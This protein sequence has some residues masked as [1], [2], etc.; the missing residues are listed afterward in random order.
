MF[1][2]PKL[3]LEHYGTKPLRKED[4]VS[5]G[6]KFEPTGEEYDLAVSLVT[7]NTANSLKDVAEYLE[8]TAPDIKK[9]YIFVNSGSI[10][11]SAEL[12]PLLPFD[13]VVVSH[14]YDEAIE[15]RYS[16]A[17]ALNDAFAIAHKLGIKYLLV[18]DIDAYVEEEGL[19]Q[20]FNVLKKAPKDVIAV[21]CPPTGGYEHRVEGRKDEATVLSW[22]SGWT[23]AITKVEE[24][25]KHWGWWS[26]A[27]MPCLGIDSD[28][29]RRINETPYKRL[30]DKNYFHDHYGNIGL[31]TTAQIGGIPVDRPD[32]IGWEDAYRRIWGGPTGKEKFQYPLN[33]QDCLRGVSYNFTPIQDNRIYR[34][35]DSYNLEGVP[36][37]CLPTEA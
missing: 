11:H 16:L 20:M 35:V 2:K 3:E 34:R 27:L 12:L 14:T 19:Y 6:V 23:A 21:T 8:T 33:R 36:K 17:S 18:H 9:K 29:N 13:K 31:K 10:D 1:R 15:H 32:G 4:W 7:Y 37:L 26:E 28:L 5:R 22:G 30:M 25:I 24:H